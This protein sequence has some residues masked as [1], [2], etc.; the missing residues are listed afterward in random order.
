MEVFNALC[1]GS[2]ASLGIAAQGD[3][4]VNGIER[5]AVQT[6]RALLR[7]IDT[8]LLHHFYRQWMHAFRD[9]AGAVNALAVGGKFP[10]EAFG[11]LAAA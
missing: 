5:N 2:A 4:L 9:G 7:Y 10:G 11:H 1:Y 3:D 6:F 8:C